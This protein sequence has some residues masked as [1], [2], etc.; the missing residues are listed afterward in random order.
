MNLIR[1]WLTAC[2]PRH[3][4][5]PTPNDIENAQRI[6]LAI[7]NNADGHEYLALQ[8]EQL[9]MERPNLNNHGECA[10][11]AMRVAV[12]GDIIMGMDKAK[13]STKWPALEQA[14][15]AGRFDP[16]KSKQ[17]YGAMGA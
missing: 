17:S 2:F 14:P 15:V 9:L 11:Y 5:F 8:L 1:Q 7:F 6:H 12:I 3:R 13:N 4:M 10:G 16:R